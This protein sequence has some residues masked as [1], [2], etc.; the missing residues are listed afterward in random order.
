MELCLGPLDI[1]S[2]QLFF[3]VKNTQI[4]STSLP[5]NLRISLNFSEFQLNV[6][7][8][9]RDAVKLECLVLDGIVGSKTR[10]CVCRSSV[11]SADA[12]NS[13]SHDS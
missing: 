4:S 9:R 1:L 11:Y 8:T 6:G 7:H 10:V 13:K 12:L 2:Y 3:S 5:L